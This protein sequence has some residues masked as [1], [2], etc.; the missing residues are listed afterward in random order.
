MAIDTAAYRIENARLAG[1]G[2]I[3]LHDDLADL[4]ATWVPAAGMLGASLRHRGRELLWNG[5]GVAAYAG[6]RVFMGIPFLHPWANRLDGMSYRAGG[7]DVVLDSASP[8]LLLDDGGLPIHGVLNATRRWAVREATADEAGARL[9]AELDYDGATLLSVFPF[10]HRLAMAVEVGAGALTVR[11]TLTPTGTQ[12]V[13]LA[14]GF[15]PY[16]HLPDAPRAAWDVAF[17]VGRQL[18]HDRRQVPT[19]ATERVAPIDGRVGARTWDD[20]YDE[21]GTPARFEL[22]GGGRTVGVE[23]LE[24]FGVA[25]I[26]APPEQ[27]YICVEPMTAPANALTGPDAAL[28]WVA[29]G[30]S[31]AAAFRITCGIDA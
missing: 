28:A 14:F 24:G 5:A 11:V 16:I 25:Q 13:P 12:P 20:G 3:V 26:F 4:H 23:F 7:H 15:H 21:L 22:R 2:A 27:D 30:G 6:R 18:L 8:L 9:V 31:G 1:L 17:P 10:P 29:P 19:G